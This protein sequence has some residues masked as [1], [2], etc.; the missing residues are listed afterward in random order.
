MI[1]LRMLNANNTD[2]RPLVAACFIS[3][4]TTL[5]NI[6]NFAILRLRPYLPPKDDIYRRIEK[7]K[8]VLAFFPCGVY[9]ELD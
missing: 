7:D 3:G 8:T 6:L 4:I 1:S 9:R 2:S 5:G